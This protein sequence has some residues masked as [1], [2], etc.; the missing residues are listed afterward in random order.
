MSEAFRLSEGPDG[1]AFLAFDS[2]GRT[3]NVLDRAALAELVD[4]VPRLA[5]R[6][7]L[8]CLV[9]LSAKPGSFIAGADL[10]EI[11]G[12][13]EAEEAAAASRY[14]QQLFAAWETLPCPTV[15][16]V[17]GTCVGGGTELALASDYIVVSDALATRIGLPEVRLGILPA[18]GGCT[19]L[20]ER[21]GLAAALDLILTGK[22]VPGRKAFELGL[23]HAV[24][25]AASFAHAL[26]DFASSVARGQ[27]PHRR[28][29][30]GLSSLLLEKNLLGRWLVYRQARRRVL[31][32][33]RGHYPAPV[34]ALAAVRAGVERSRRAG[35]AAETKA[36]A[37]L[38]V[39]PVCKSLVHVFRLTEAARKRA[40]AAPAP[41]RAV[42]VLGAGVMGGGIAQLIAQEAGVPVRLKDIETEA[43]AAAMAHAGEG[44]RRLV[45]RR[46]LSAAAARA[47]MGLLRASLEES[48][49]AGVDLVIEAIVE[50]LEVKRSVLGELSRRLSPEAVIATNT[51][52]L[53]IDAI[54]RDVERPER[55]VGMHFFNPVHTMPLVE[56]V[57]GPRTSPKVVAAVAAFSR[58]LGKTP[59][60]VRD[61]PG[62]LVNRLLVFSLA[63]ALA[64]LEEG[65]AIERLDATMRAWGMPLGPIELVDDVG[66]DVAMHAGRVVEEAFSDRLHLP[67]WLEMLVAESRL[68]RKAGR[69]FY[70]YADGR[71]QGPDGAVARRFGPHGRSPA[72]EALLAERLVLPMVNEAAR[73]LEE[74]V[75]GSAAE[76][77]LAMILG[78]G[79]PPFRGGL[80]RWA[81]EQG[82]GGLV[83]RLAELAGE[84]GP[85]FA[86]APALEAVAAAG[87]F[88]ASHPEAAS[89]RRATG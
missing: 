35:F 1:V 66:L 45:A 19:R 29:R 88:Y 32:E 37:S 69:G 25:P 51:S 81:D 63:E 50:K 78:T 38:A 77:D 39:S 49:L 74:G 72:R 30:P 42:G 75:V 83:E 89:P 68:G 11:A 8:K 73:C 71:R 55:V 33:T 4:L 41:I 26:R 61:G 7:A 34:Q 22:I 59:I 54:A 20:P 82:I 28:R 70:R 43:L 10:D 5:A 58:E 48:G 53:S 13:T 24:L 44:F 84:V 47:K 76:V 23:A 6:G 27:Q 57:A 62:F 14:G 3:V 86:P 2:P 52:S 80:C 65:V 40:P 64:L 46:R 31:G 85:R 12:I 16:A 67:A 56:V 87:G 18:W 17:D 9:L 21:V 79:F 15:A 36:L 60:L